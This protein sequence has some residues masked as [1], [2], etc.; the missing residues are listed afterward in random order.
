MQGRTEGKSASDHQTVSSVISNKS[1]RLHLAYSSMSAGSR[2]GRDR[3]RAMERSRHPMSALLR[4]SKEQSTCAPRVRTRSAGDLCAKIT[5]R[6]LTRGP[7]PLKAE[8]VKTSRATEFTT[9]QPGRQPG[10]EGVGRCLL[11]LEEQNK[12]KN[13]SLL[14]VNSLLVFNRINL[15]TVIRILIP[16]ARSFDKNC[17]HVRE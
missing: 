5:T 10:S 6:P 12:R 3:E 14:V 9:T 13:A 17:H 1:V 11:R 7:T 4:S 2:E 8:R 16:V 15:M